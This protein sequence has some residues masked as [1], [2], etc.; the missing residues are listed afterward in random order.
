M[1]QLPIVYLPTLKEWIYTWQM[2]RTVFM[3]KQII[4]IVVEKF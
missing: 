2:L 3:F 1:W 4:Y